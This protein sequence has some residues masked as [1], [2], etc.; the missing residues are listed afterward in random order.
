MP[1]FIGKKLGRYLLSYVTEKAWSF[2]INRFWVHTCSLDHPSAV[3][4]Y[5]EGGFVEYK[6]EIEWSDGL[7][8]LAKQ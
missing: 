6:T 5:K 7:S 3:K 8:V 1:E 4:V 2:G